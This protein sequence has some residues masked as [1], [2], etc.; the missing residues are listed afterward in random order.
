MAC[1][2]RPLVCRT[3]TGALLVFALTT[4]HLDAQ[5]IPAV[6]LSVSSSGEQANGESVRLGYSRDLRHIL[7]RSGASNL[8]PGDA[9]GVEDLFI[10]DRDTDR[11]GVFDESGAVSTI[12]ASVGSHGEQA[13]SASVDAILSPDGRFVLF[14][15]EASTLI[16]GDTNGVSDVFLRDRDTDADGVFDE[17]E[18]VSTTRISEG[19][20]GVQANAH[21]TRLTM[22]PD[23]RFILFVSAASTFTPQ[24]VNQVPQ[25]Y[26]KDRATGALTLI[27]RSADGLPANGPSDMG[28]LSDDGRIVAFRS[29]AGNLG[30]GPGGVQ[31]AYVRDLAADRIVHA[32]DPSPSQPTI[33]NHVVPDPGVAPDGSAVY[34]TAT[35]SDITRGTNMRFDGWLYEFDVQ[36]GTRRLAALGNRFDFARDSRYITFV[37]N[38]GF[39]L[40]CR[41]DNGF[42]RFDRVTRAITPLVQTYVNGVAA[43]GSLDRILFIEPRMAGCVPS[44]NNPPAETTNNLFDVQYGARLIM[45]AL[46]VP[47]PLNEDG[48]E[49]LVQTADATL[50]PGVDTNNYGDIYAVNLN[51]MLDRD[52]DRLDD[53]WEAATGLSYTSGAGA[54]GPSGDPDGD[55]VANLQEQAAHSHPRGAVVRYLAEGAENAFFKTTLALANA[56]TTPAAA[57]VRILGDQGQSNAVFISVP[58][59]GQRTLAMSDADALPTASFSMVVESDVPL[60]IERTMSWTA[61]SGY[62]GHAERAIADLSTTWFLAE[63]STTGEF[64]LFYLLQNPHDTEVRATIRYLRPAG[65]PPVERIYSLAPNSRLTIPVNGE[66]PELASTDVSAAIAAE[67]PILVERAMY[68]SR[69]GQPFAAGHAS[70]GV[71]APAGSWF[72]GEGATGDF[73][74]LFLL[75]A[76]P[77]GTDAV[78]EARYLLSD[79]RVFTKTYDVR[80]NS[81][82]TIWV[83]GEEI[84]GHGRVLTNVDVSTVLTSVNAVPIIAERA[85]WFPGPAITPLF[86]TEAHVSAGSTETAAR[87]VV[88]DAY[89]GGP[90]NVQTFVLVAN[91]SNVDA[92]V[93]FR[94]LNTYGYV[95][96]EHIVPANSRFTLP[97]RSLHTG[98]GTYDSD[99]TSG[100]PVG[101]IVES[102]GPDPVAQIVVERSTYWDAL[103]VTWA[104]GTNVL[105]TPV[106]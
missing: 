84:P 98:F 75:V 80:A 40:G 105:A 92:R 87:W 94:Y 33:I 3:L 51:A 67:R 68:L 30:G 26:R 47:G 66:G 35:R 6:R 20:G 90:A 100:H 54:D 59:L 78:V 56:G 71:T 61:T 106:P 60:A 45:P 72:F 23:A 69:F 63:G 86:W 57:L 82:L 36:T 18:A 13:D 77:T 58:A 74:D 93:Q 102:V 91:T 9:N 43:S 62:G 81:R 96:L 7:F 42:H 64:S 55:G 73:F 44:R 2:E 1:L 79:G 28:S 19:V 29:E 10:R 70:V 14:S 5:T 25:I 22:T 52:G 38:G 24:P 8:V 41:Y 34:I 12:R 85:M 103:G 104:A 11:D 95:Q 49:L 15:T 4:A 53:R 97:V 46:L 39:L 65:L 37:G 89:E 83:D 101:L 76:N 16:A 48:S 32:F 88:A 50:L 27:T 21:A 31:R 17:P 99:F